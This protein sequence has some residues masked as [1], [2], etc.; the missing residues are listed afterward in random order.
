MDKLKETRNMIGEIFLEIGEAMDSGQFGSQS[1][2]GITALGSEHGIDNIIKGAEK[3][4]KEN[5]GLKVVLIGPKV[6]T[7]LE[8]VEANSESD[9][10]TKMEELLDKGEINACVT[11]HYN[12]PIGVATVGKAITPGL[13]KDIYLATTT[14][15]A[16]TNRVEAMIKNALYGIITAKT[17]GIVN[18]SVGIL[19][20]DGSRQ[21]ETAL[22]K[23]NANGYGINFGDS[24]RAD[25]GCVMRG[26]DLLSGSS[27]VM[28]TDTLTGNIMMKV[29]SS[30]TTGGNY[31]SSG[32]GYGPG[33]GENYDKIILILSRASGVPVVANAIGYAA[34]LV[35]GR[36]ID[37]ANE[38]FKKARD[39][40]L[41]SILK[42]LTKE[43]AKSEKQIL[44]PDKE[45]VTGQISGI[46]IMDLESAVQVLW[47]EHIYAESGMGCTGPIILVSEKNLA[48]AIDILQRNSFVATEAEDC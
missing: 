21:V 23:L 28:V 20:L 11:M 42:D 48:N 40:G 38:E 6:D 13:G 32:Y 30:F 12:F 26:N 17:M 29:F 44:M 3:A 18:P 25:G 45:V 33:I 24:A 36:L 46:D 8:V 1:R 10:Y 14:G 47:Q 27:D 9:M 34:R 35:N 2:I 15:T 4:Q 19:N 5:T 22:K 31:E 16:S 37:V 41:Q 39:A 7:D 43:P